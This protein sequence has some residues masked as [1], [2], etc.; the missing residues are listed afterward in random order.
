[1]EIAPLLTSFVSVTDQQQS[2]KKLEPANKTTASGK[3]ERS[4]HCTGCKS[5]KCN[6]G[7]F[8]CGMTKSRCGKTEE[9]LPSLAM[10][11]D[12]NYWYPILPIVS[13]PSTKCHIL[14]V[15]SYTTTFVTSS[16]KTTS[17][18]ASSHCHIN[19][20]NSLAPTRYTCTC[21]LRI[22]QLVYVYYHC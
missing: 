8:C 1:M 14:P 20:A 3:K 17:S 9:M 21:F 2:C 13:F 5:H 11:K 7:H 6:I 10:H 15:A 19:L 18:L 16:H 12:A 4:G 22:T